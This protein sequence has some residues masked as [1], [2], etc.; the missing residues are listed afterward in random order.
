[1]YTKKM[2]SLFL[3]S[4]GVEF[5]KVNPNGALMLLSCRERKARPYMLILLMTEMS[6]ILWAE[7]QPR[8]CAKVNLRQS[9]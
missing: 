7:K 1:M 6:N 5:L 8:N 4:I 3:W 2:A 9:R